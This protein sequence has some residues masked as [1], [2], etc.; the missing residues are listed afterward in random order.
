MLF[1]LKLNKYTNNIIP[2]RNRVGPGW[3]CV[4][5]SGAHDESYFDDR[6]CLFCVNT[7]FIIQKI[8]LF[9]GYKLNISVHTSHYVCNYYILCQ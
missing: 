2:K 9:S 8:L 1:L 3:C 4:G 7:R 6:N 5:V